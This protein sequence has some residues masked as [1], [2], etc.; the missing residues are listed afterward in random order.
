MIYLLHGENE[1]DRSE[2]LHSLIAGLGE[3]DTLNFVELDGR[4]LTKEELQH[5]ADVPPF[6][7]EHRLIVVHG[8]VMRLSATKTGGKT[9]TPSSFLQWLIDY[10]PSVPSSTIL[11][12]AENKEIPAK[13]PVVRAV[14]KLEKSGKVLNFRAPSARGDEIEKWVIGNAQKLGARLERGVAADLARF[15]GPDLRLIHSELVKLAAYADDRAITRADVRLLV[16]YAQ[17]A[18]IFAMV[19]A[20]GNRQTSQA[21]RL[22]AQLRNE[23]AHPLYLLTMIVRQFRIL[24][25]IKDLS[26]RKMA[27]DT[28]A[29]ELRMKPWMVRKLLSQTHRYSQEQLLTIYDRLLDVDVAIKTGQMEAN[30]ALDLLVVELARA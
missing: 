27:Q 18:N 10:I 5:H 23:G 30:L 11:V 13:N 2:Y 21:F 15:I 22:L 29:K 19:D 1:F 9:K 7:G 20:L 26:S 16:P 4:N 28:I 12:F 6:L 17:D 8:L 25:Q 14:S 24:I 3:Y